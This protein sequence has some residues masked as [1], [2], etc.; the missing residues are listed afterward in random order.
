ML[1]SHAKGNA[2]EQS[3]CVLRLKSALAS[4]GYELKLRYAPGRPALLLASTGQVDGDLARS[5]QIED[6]Y[7]NL[8]RVAMPCANLKPALYGLAQESMSWQQRRLKK[9]AYFRGA[10]RLMSSLV[11]TLKGYELVYTGSS[12]QSLKLLQAHRVDAVFISKPMFVQLGRVQPDLV[13]GVAQLT[14][15]LEE[16]KLYTYLHKSHE[17]LIVQLD[18]LMALELT[19]LPAG[20]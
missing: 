12:E 3:P 9:I 14:P 4:L 17:G 15:E 5:N 6:E 19:G 2:I 13:S 8:R 18:K 11:D 10:T 16:V 7:T 20:P 1:P